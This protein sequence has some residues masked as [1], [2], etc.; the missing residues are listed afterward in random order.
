MACSA[1]PS[2]ERW[3]AGAGGPAR[4]RDSK[5]RSRD[6]GGEP[7]PPG[8]ALLDGRQA[9]AC[10]QRLSRCGMPGLLPWARRSGRYDAGGAR[11]WATKP[12]SGGR[13]RTGATRPDQDIF[14]RGCST[15]RKT[16]VD[17]LCRLR[18]SGGLS[19]AT[20]ARQVRKAPAGMAPDDEF[21]AWSS[22]GPRQARG[23]A[24]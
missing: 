8:P 17:V 11:K 19:A 16:S 5:A 13:S 10:T 18:R 4:A 20:T 15:R 1:W 6:A 2:W 24:P 9:F 21:T 22:P 3:A 7:D 23:T 12:G 14:K